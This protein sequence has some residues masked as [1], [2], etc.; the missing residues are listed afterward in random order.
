ME[1]ANTIEI[2]AATVGVIY[3]LLQYRA[4]AWMW[5]FSLAMSLMYVYLNYVNGLYAN[6]VLQVVFS[7]MAVVGLI[8]WLRPP[9]GHTYGKAAQRPITS[10]PRRLLLPVV[11]VTLLLTAAG[12]AV[13]HMVGESQMILF[14]G[15]TT[16]INLTG[17]WMLIRKYYQEWICWMIVDPLMC[18]MYALSG[19]WPSAVLYAFFSVVVVFGYLQ[20]KKQALQS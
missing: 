5:V 1:A 14:D 4:S 11:L 18:V 7:V 10:M 12:M 13:L 2:I 15:L 16:A 9:A 17:T 19:M 3:L 20:W 6:C 8:A